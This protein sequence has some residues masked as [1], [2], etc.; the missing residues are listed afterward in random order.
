VGE[1]TAAIDHE[2]FRGLHHFIAR[3][4]EY[5]SWEAR[6]CIALGADP[7]AWAAL[8]RRQRRKYEN[9]SRWW[10]A[11]AYFLFA[12]IPRMGFLDGPQGFIYAV[13]K[14]VYFMD[15]RLKIIEMTRPDEPIDG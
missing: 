11:P 9:L 6:R 2:D 13:F 10:F 4:N 7:A 3:H 12:Y 14:A 5:S 1:I 8:T 15:V